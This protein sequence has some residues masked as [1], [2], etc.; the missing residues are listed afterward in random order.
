[1]P[2]P[3][4]VP[5]G[6]RPARPGQDAP[7]PDRHPGSDGAATGTWRRPLATG[8]AGPSRRTRDLRGGMVVLRDRRCPHRIGA[9]R[10][11]TPQ[12]PA[13]SDW[14]SGDALF[15]GAVLAAGGLVALVWAGAALSALVS[16]SR[17]P[18]GL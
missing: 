10:P 15:V 12:S 14:G 9:M 3:G 16:G 17:L 1:R 5:P 6:T 13:R 4:R 7:R 2:D 18:G 11:M 8:R